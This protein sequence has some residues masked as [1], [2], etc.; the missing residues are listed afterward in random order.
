MRGHTFVGWIPNVAGRLSFSHI[1]SSH[2]P[3]KCTKANRGTPDGRRLA[4]AQRRPLNDW[5][6]PDWYFRFL[7]G[8]SSDWIFA[9]IGETEPDKFDQIA[10]VAGEAFIIERQ[11]WTRTRD[12]A[13]TISLEDYFRT[14]AFSWVDQTPN[15]VNIDDIT[16]T[17]REE[18]LFSFD[19]KIRRSGVVW[20]QPK[21]M[22]A[23]IHFAETYLKTDNRSSPDDTAYVANQVFFFLKDVSHKHQHHH[24][25]SDTI[26]ELGRLDKRHSWVIQTHYRIH[27]KI[28]ELRRSDSPS[29]LYNAS[30]ILAYLAALRKAAGYKDGKSRGPLTYNHTEIEQ[31]LKSSL[32]VM[33]WKQTQLNIIRTA[34]PALFVAFVGVLGYDEAAGT[35]IRST[36]NDIVGDSIFRWAALGTLVFV[37][38]LF[39]YGVASFNELPVVVNSKRILVNLPKRLHS[40]CWFIG[41]VFFSL[42]AFSQTRLSYFASMMLSK[43]GISVGPQL[44]SWGIVLLATG[45]AYIGLKSLPLLAASG[46]LKRKISRGSTAALN[47]LVQRF[48]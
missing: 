10:R 8:F 13:S 29:K 16:R 35:Y 9:F 38:A 46:A 28:I 45:F 31:S 20:I 39:Y 19:V 24:A 43:L 47:A 26:T 2:F 42:V 18:S 17:I 25:S 12:L 23:D 3:T 41:F 5:L 4:V 30:G 40:A 15:A 21:Y 22:S 48:V 33:K 1:G 34:F 27:R 14:F 11:D 36:L 32:E 7:Y 6:L 37:A 44:T